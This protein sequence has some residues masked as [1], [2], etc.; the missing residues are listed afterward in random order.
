[1]RY[2]PK[3]DTLA[4][5]VVYG[6]MAAGAVAFLVAAFFSTG[7]TAAQI[8][9]VLFFTVGFVLTGR[10]VFTAFTYAVEPS[11]FGEET[12]AFLGGTDVRC[13]PLS[14]LDFTVRVQKGRRPPALEARLC[15]SSLVALEP[16][17]KKREERK[18]CLSAFPAARLYDYTAALRP[19]E[20]YLAVFREGEETVALAF[21]P[22]EEMVAFLSRA[23][24]RD[25]R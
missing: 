21:E 4:P 2:T 19:R 8:I 5:R 17:P 25:G 15:L 9:G 13:L 7:R 11:S 18:T 14:A 12:P 16:W 3:K 20:G 23:V 22:G 1:M 6:C 24:G 10:Y